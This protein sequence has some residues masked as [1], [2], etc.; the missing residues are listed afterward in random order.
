MENN[1]T[2]LTG[3]AIPEEKYKPRKITLNRI[4][5]VI[6]SWIKDIAVAFVIVLLLYTYVFQLSQIKGNSM[7]PTLKDG[8]RVIVEKITGWAGEFDRGDIITLKYPRDIDKNYVKRIIAFENETIAIRNG[9]VYI[10]GRLLDEPYVKNIEP[11]DN[12]LPVTVPE[13]YL[14]VMGDNRPASSDSR[15]WGFL[16]KGYAY[17][18]VVLIIWP[19][20]DIG[21][22][23]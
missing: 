18:K 2:E 1:E 13:G 12:M 4:R 6:W 7:Y 21:L 10:N 11:Y 19:P 15:R 16:P 14:F 8:E 20:R 17:G 3:K 22:I 9:H 5:L 23:E